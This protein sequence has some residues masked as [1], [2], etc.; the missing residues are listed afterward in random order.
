MT[1]LVFAEVVMIDHCDL[2]ARLKR[3]KSKSLPFHE[4]HQKL[5]F[6]GLPDD[7]Q[8]RA[9]AVKRIVLHSCHAI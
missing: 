4:P 6:R 2:V 9:V 3:G 8:V 1:A 5:V 7:A